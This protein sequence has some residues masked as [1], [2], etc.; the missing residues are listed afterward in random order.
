[1]TQYLT[2]MHNVYMLD[3]LLKVDPDLVNPK[4]N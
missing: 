3:K 1:M 4:T 2:A